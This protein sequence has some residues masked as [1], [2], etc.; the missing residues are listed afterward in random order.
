MSE[1]G[2]KSRS[3]E[4]GG[5]RARDARRVAARAERHE[6]EDQ[7]L[8]DAIE[9]LPRKRKLSDTWW[10]GYA[11]H[12]SNGGTYGWLRA[13]LGWGRKKLQNVVERL[14]RAGKIDRKSFFL[15][16]VE[17]RAGRPKTVMFLRLC[18]E[19]LPPGVPEEYRVQYFPRKLWMK[20]RRKLFAP[21]K[22]QPHVVLIP[23]A[24]HTATT[25]A[26]SPSRSNIRGGTNRAPERALQFEGDSPEAR[27]RGDHPGD[28]KARERGRPLPWKLGR[29]Q[30]SSP[31]R[32]H[33]Q[34]PIYWSGM[35]PWWPFEW[36]P[37]IRVWDP[38]TEP[39]PDP[40]LLQRLAEQPRV[41]DL[42][43]GKRYR[44]H[45]TP[46]PKQGQIVVAVMGFTKYEHRYLN[47][48]Y[49]AMRRAEGSISQGTLFALACANFMTMDGDGLFH[50][51]SA[52]DVE[53]LIRKMDGVEDQRRNRL[54]YAWKDNL[55]NKTVLEGLEAAQKIVPR[56]QTACCLI[57]E[58]W[59]KPH[60]EEQRL[61]GRS[62]RSV[63]WTGRCG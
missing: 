11:G 27:P 14:Y 54:I 39:H 5:H 13:R 59:W 51:L 6:R 12:E 32:P 17:P 61:T 43:D 2:I 52:R 60:R 42:G 38:A 36:K 3:R 58:C 33:P 4:G 53:R 63:G 34:R 29:S 24:T 49:R 1:A 40:D 55:F 44:F 45:E 19:W 47:G 25:Q 57:A 21:K 56:I 15:R 18:G 50:G 10:R 26:S 8:R 37:G 35:P 16:P 22:E 41:A 7:A 62:L 23:S 31:V 30:R 28:Q 9:V 48:F 20:S 46:P